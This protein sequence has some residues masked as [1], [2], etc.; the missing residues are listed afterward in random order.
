MAKF[1]VHVPVEGIEVYEIDANDME[2]ARMLVLDGEG[3]Q[4]SYDIE[5]NGANADVSPI[6]EGEA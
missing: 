1:L 5:W 3:D 6:I 4:V 2:Q